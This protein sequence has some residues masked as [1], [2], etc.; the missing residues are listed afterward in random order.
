MPAPE[1]IRTGALSHDPPCLWCGHGPHRYLPCDNDAC[2]C[3]HAEQLGID[4][5]LGG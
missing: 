4:T 3:T 2:A 5:A 1:E